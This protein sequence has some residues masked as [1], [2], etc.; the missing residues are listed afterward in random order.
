MGKLLFFIIVFLLIGSFF[1]ISQQNLDIKNKTDQQTFLKSFG[2]WLG[3]VGKNM[4]QV[5]SYAVKMAWLPE[6]NSTE[7]LKN[8]T[9]STK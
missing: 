3:Q 9:N 5:S 6:K 8:A 2:S 1:V 7:I 4:V